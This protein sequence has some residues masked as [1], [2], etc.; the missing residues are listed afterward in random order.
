METDYLDIEIL[1]SIASQSL[2]LGL[3]HMYITGGEP[4]LYPE[5]ILK[6]LTAVAN[7]VPTT[8]FTNGCESGTNIRQ[9][10][11]S[12]SSKITVRLTVFSISPSLH[13]SVTGISGSFN[14][15]I[16]ASTAWLTSNACVEWVFIPLAR[17][18]LEFDQVCALAHQ[19]G[20]DSIKIS[21][22]VKTGRAKE[23]WMNLTPSVRDYEL[24]ENQILRAE[25]TTA[26]TLLA[27]QH[28][29]M[30]KAGKNRVFIQANGNTYP[31]P[32]LRRLQELRGPNAYT[33]SMDTIWRHL[34]K[35]CKHHQTT[36][37]QQSNS[38]FSGFCSSYCPIQD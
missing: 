19:K 1:K 5:A 18:I 9:S 15:L 36:I 35:S 8:I 24:F 7:R 14:R 25:R 38:P 31:C 11:T 28:N 29:H 34:Y 20:I 3:E 21:R 2:S 12:L 37:N 4:F 13:D 27:K 6:L 17:N 33:E 10:V 23:H 16:E 26:K 32:A 22:L 30:C